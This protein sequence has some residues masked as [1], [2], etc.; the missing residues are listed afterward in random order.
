MN[1]G[2]PTR[3]SA[4]AVDMN[5][6]IFLDS[7]PAWC[8]EDHIEIDNL[9]CSHR[10]PVQ[11]PCTSQVSLPHS[12]TYVDPFVPSP[13]SYCGDGLQVAR[14]RTYNTPIFHLGKKR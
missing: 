6:Q 10:D 3:R 9:T 1:R 12:G 8:E 5:R 7:E 4:S 13:V 2:R 14:A 11:G